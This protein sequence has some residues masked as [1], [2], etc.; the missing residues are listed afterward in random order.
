MRKSKGQQWIEALEWESKTLGVPSIVSQEIQK[1]A[2]KALKKAKPYK[3]QIRI[4]KESQRVP[5]K[6]LVKELDRVF[7]IFTRV[8]D[9]EGI[10]GQ[11]VTCGLRKHWRNMDA[12]HYIPRQD[13]ATRWDARNV[14]IQCKMCNGFRGGEPEAMAAYIDMVYGVGT[15]DELRAKKRTKFIPNRGWLE[16]KIKEYK[17]KIGEI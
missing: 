11:C 10:I 2:A 5:L 15:T 9:S 1:Q 16:T 14:H 4:P 8:R 13:M 3:P 17:L 6:K 7:S 12:G